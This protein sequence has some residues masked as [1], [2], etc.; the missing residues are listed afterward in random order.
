MAK[1]K[2]DV[3]TPSNKKLHRDG[4]RLQDLMTKASAQN[5]AMKKIA[6]RVK[7]KEE[8]IKRG[9]KDTNGGFLPRPAFDR[10][11]D[12]LDRLWRTSGLTKAY[13]LD[14]KLS[15]RVISL[16][17]KMLAYTPNNSTDFAWQ[18]VALNALI[19]YRYGRKMLSDGREEIAAF[20]NK[21]AKAAK[22]KIKD[23]ELTL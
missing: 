23:G 4:L 9:F 8:K 21:V 19:V 16:A 5:A 10:Q 20:L 18:A 22:I 15:G 3:T 7:P 6:K 1:A 13:N 12:A 2:N 17:E 14:C 11:H